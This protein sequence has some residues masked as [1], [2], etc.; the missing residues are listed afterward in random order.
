M[1]EG[2][3]YFDVRRW[4]EGNRLAAD[5]E[6]V[7]A[8][9]FPQLASAAYRKNKDGFWSCSGTVLLKIPKTTCGLCR[10][11]SGKEIQI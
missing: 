4:K 2:Q 8:S 5:I 1:L 7:K 10:R 9:W 11:H 3:R 6:G